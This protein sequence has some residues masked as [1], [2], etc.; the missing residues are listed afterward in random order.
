MDSH[1]RFK[2]RFWPSR[3]VIR[4][5]VELDLHS[6]PYQTAPTDHRQPVF[7]HQSLGR[8]L[9]EKRTQ[10]S[11]APLRAF[12]YREAKPGKLPIFGGRPQKGNGPVKLQTSRRLSSGELLATSQDSRRTLEEIREGE[13]VVGVKSRRESRAQSV[14]SP[15]LPQPRPF[16]P[17][18][19][20]PNQQ[21]PS[22][23]QSWIHP[24]GSN[25]LMDIPESPTT[26][27]ISTPLSVQSAPNPHLG[28]GIYTHSTMS[29]DG[30]GLSG[31]GFP[32]P[33]A[34]HGILK[35]STTS[36]PISILEPHEEQNPTIRALWK[37]EY[38]RLVSIYGQAGVDRHVG[39][40]RADRVTPQEEIPGFVFE[41]QAPPQPPFENES[42]PGSRLDRN[43]RL[44][45]HGSED[46]SDESS[47]QRHSFM[48]S[49][50]YASS[51]TTR[52]SFAETDSINTR[53][54][55]RK[56]VDDMRSTYL[57]AIEAREPS[58]QAVKSLKKKKKKR[59]SSPPSAAGTPRASTT[60]PPSTPLR[61]P[62]T[63]EPQE[64]PTP[65]GPSPPMHSQRSTRNFSS[66][67]AGINKLP[68]IEASPSRERESEVG[69]KR[70]DSSTLGALMGETKRASIQKRRSKRHSRRLSSNLTPP[71][72]SPTKYPL[73]SSNEE[74]NDPEMNVLDEEFQ[75][76]YKD[77]F[78]TSTHEFWTSP[79]SLS[80]T[81][82]IPSSMPS[83]D[84]PPPPIPT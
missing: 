64:R 35:S 30:L 48:S 22:S 25:A 69:L 40:L 33:S 18:T 34:P 16:E 17:V 43:S 42:S 66:P 15:S 57:R 83:P 32:L 23:Q 72:N 21:H 55:I 81:I 47:Q 20:S 76:L 37:A 46:I 24:T 31:T 27:F 8:N 79:S 10:D 73:Q 13:Y 44:D 82:G 45:N 38:G 75:N 49:V 52:T 29:V 11:S 59:R 68:A 28:P 9:S 50:G 60:I 12:S 74:N 65:K 53:D 67:I 51:Y 80:S 1:S 77:I 7:I 56:M 78:R 58:L 26:E 54:D 63:P 14:R 61:K 62:I 36:L 19:I 3:R 71:K 84:R 39:E 6:V 70:A 41:P 2:I 4:N 5:P